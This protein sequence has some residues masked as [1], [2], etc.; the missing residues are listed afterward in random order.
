MPRQLR[1]PLR[2]LRNRFSPPRIRTGPGT[3]LAFDPGPSNP[4]YATGDNELPVQEAFATHV[5]RGDVVFDIG[6]NVGFF[7]VLAARLVGPEGHVYAFEPVPENVAVLRR[8]LALNDLR[9]VT[10]VERAITDHVGEATMI[11]AGY[12]GGHGLDTSPPPDATGSMTVAASTVDALVASGEVPPPR[13]VKIDVEGAELEVL[14]GMVDTL[15]QHDLTLICE[16]DDGDRASYAAR[17]ESSV[18]I[19][20]GCGY[21][22][23]ALADSYPGM[24]WIVGHFVARKPERSNDAG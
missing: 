20:A 8:N 6:A 24:E 11:I 19:L 12:A 5:R 18:E 21:E 15:E 16:V 4:D 2:R 13:F 14:R 9:N 7:T 1:V 23:E 22:S 17:Y 10:V 3:G